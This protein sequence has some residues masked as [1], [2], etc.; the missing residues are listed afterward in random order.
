[1]QWGHGCRDVD[2]K[3]IEITNYKLQQNRPAKTVTIVG[4]LK[5][6][7]Q[8]QPCPYNT[9]LFVPPKNGNNFARIG[10]IEL[11]NAIMRGKDVG[12]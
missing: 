11:I 3:L 10:K 6:I 5:M 2:R 8:G 12:A 9:T 1:M 7:G 4:K